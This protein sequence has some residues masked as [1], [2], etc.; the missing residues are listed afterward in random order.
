MKRKMTENEKTVMWQ[1]I[2]AMFDKF[3]DVFDVAGIE[4]E[5]TKET[6]LMFMTKD[7]KNF[8]KVDKAIEAFLRCTDYPVESYNE[9]YGVKEND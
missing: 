3:A 9:R 7:G 4:D 6:L 5:E 2:K 1:G 8:I